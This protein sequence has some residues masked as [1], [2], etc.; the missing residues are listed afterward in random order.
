MQCIATVSYSVLVN[1]S[2]SKILKPACGLRQGDPLSPYL[3]VLCMEALSRNLQVAEIQ[4]Q[5]SGIKIGRN[6]KAISHL[7]FADD[8]N[9]YFK[10]DLD[11]CARVKHVFDNYALASGQVINFNKLGI[12][13]SNNLPD[14]Q[15]TVIQDFF[16]GIKCPRIKTIWGPFCSLE[17]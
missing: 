9:V 3:F 8:C 6:S 2:P 5:F 14:T 17:K 15:A 12:G 7:F 10:C 4:N 1:E 11:A 16:S 13:V